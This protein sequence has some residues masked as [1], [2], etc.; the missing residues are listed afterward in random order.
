MPQCD[1]QWQ[2]FADSCRCKSVNE[3]RFL[4]KPC[5]CPM[6]RLPPTQAHAQTTEESITCHTRR[7]NR[8]T[9]TWITVEHG[10]KPP[11]L[12]KPPPHCIRPPGVPARGPCVY[13]PPDAV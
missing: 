3:H 6:G 12:Y 7:D 11:P 8:H 1:A 2:L 4:Y 9:H 10:Y 5:P 13:A